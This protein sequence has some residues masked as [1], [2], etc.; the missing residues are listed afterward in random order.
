MAVDFDTLSPG[1]AFELDVFLLP[2]FAP[3]RIEAFLWSSP[4]SASM[5]EVEAFIGE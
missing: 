5:P 1:G 3:D 2:L 4:D